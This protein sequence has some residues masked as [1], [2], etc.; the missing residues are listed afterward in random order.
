MLIAGNQSRHAG[1]HFVIKVICENYP[2]NSPVEEGM[3]LFVSRD[4][5]TKG[6]L[7]VSWFGCPLPI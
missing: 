7:Q 6:L 2:V 4:A 1:A 5:T 3:F